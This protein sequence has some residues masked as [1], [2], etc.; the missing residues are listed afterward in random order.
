[1]PGSGV[2]SRGVPAP[3]RSGPGVPARGGAWW[4][5]PRTATAAGGTHPTGMHSCFK[6]ESTIYL[7]EMYQQDGNLPVYSE[8]SSI[9]KLSMRCFI[10]RYESE[11]QKCSKFEGMRGGSRG[12]IEQSRV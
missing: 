12:V 3:G 9:Y 2:W 8:V 5:P 11:V 1:M 4:R 10:W 7:Q 6:Q